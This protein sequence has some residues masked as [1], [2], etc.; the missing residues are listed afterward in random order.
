M[1][2]VGGGVPERSGLAVFLATALLCGWITLLEFQLDDFVLIRDSGHQLG[3]TP[4]PVPPSVSPSQI[5]S[6]RPTLWAVLFGLSRIAALGTQPWF[7]HLAFLLA[8][9]TTAWLLYRLLRARIDELP[10]A[11]GA[12]LFGMVPGGIQA[13]T[14]ISA[15]GDLLA[16]LFALLACRA[17]DRQLQRPSFV[18]LA[19]CGAAIGLACAAKET[20]IVLIVPAFVLLFAA[21]PRDRVLRRR[22]SPAILVA[23]LLGIV[24]AWGTRAWYLS[25]LL[26]RYWRGEPFRLSQLSLLPRV[27][28]GYLLPWD[29][30]C[31][32]TPCHVALLTQAKAAPSALVAVAVLVPVGLAL[33]LGGWRKRL[34]VLAL[35]GTFGVVLLPLLPIVRPDGLGMSRACYPASAVLGALLASALAGPRRALS[36]ILLAAPFGLLC[37]DVHFAIAQAEL[38]T[39]RRI[40]AARQDYEKIDDSSPCSIMIEPPSWRGTI[41]FLGSPFLMANCPPLGPRLA[42]PS[43][44]ARRDTL[45]RCPEILSCDR[46]TTIL[47]WTGEHLARREALRPI[48]GELPGLVPADD[49]GHTFRPRS[50]VPPRAIAGLTLDVAQI[51]GQT[52]KAVFKASSQT[53]SFDFRPPTAGL[54]VV[55]IPDS[56]VD[57]PWVCD[58]ALVAVT[59]EGATLAGSPVLLRALPVATVAHDS[60]PDRIPLETPPAFDV[61]FRSAR[62]AFAA[63]LVELIIEPGGYRVPLRWHAPIDSLEARGPGVSH[64]VAKAP[65][66]M[67]IEGRP[68]TVT[69]EAI[70][71]RLRPFAHG[72]RWRLP[73]DVL[74]EGMDESGQNTVC[75]SLVHRVAFALSPAR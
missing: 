7:F 4:P 26:P 3:W 11:I 70:A 27:A 23:A 72:D 49:G 46:E 35:I 71:S 32:P 39:T 55:G 33:F 43:L 61:S 73:A 51:S 22:L 41:P 29:P 9:A 6:F 68:E 36:R 65:V 48:P 40:S 31:V 25:E 17:S 59:I 34:A 42:V 13:A 14:W 28:L 53:R 62:V 45:H 10:A 16:V 44:W 1:P 8:H 2:P 56:A 38:A 12:L 58:D 30:S 37:L 64:F 54:N 47:E 69:W 24:A 20:A 21:P 5:Y 74:V 66:T 19:V 50:P 57:T 60:P 63:V 18:N 67:A 75:R 15:G 52:C